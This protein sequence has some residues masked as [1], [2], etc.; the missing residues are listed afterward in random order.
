MSTVTR[1]DASSPER[2]VVHATFS[3]DRTYSAPRA[4]VF[5]AFSDTDKK[6]RWFAEGEG[7]EIESFNVDFRVGGLETARFRFSGGPLI[8]N[9]TTY[10]DIVKDERI[11]IAYYMT[12]AGVCISA[13][14]ATMEFLDAPGGGTLLIYTEQ[15]AYLDGADSVRMREAGCR[16]L[17]ERLAE[18]VA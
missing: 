7:W 17:L 18:E 9:D 13:S 15:G 2:S 11:I 1:S 12:V 14:L 10:Q 6:R 3:I 4:M 5:A 8:T 16:D